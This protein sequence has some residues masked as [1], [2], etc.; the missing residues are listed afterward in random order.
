MLGIKLGL[1]QNSFRNLGINIVTAGVNLFNFVIAADI[2]IEK[3]YNNDD[4]FISYGGL[5]LQYNFNLKQNVYIAPYFNAKATKVNLKS[6]N[7][8]MTITGGIS[9]NVAF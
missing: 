9:V 2:T 5:L 3:L 4:I 8:G 7:I 1:G 6:D